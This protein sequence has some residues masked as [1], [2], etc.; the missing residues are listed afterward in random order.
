MS[1]IHISKIFKNVQYKSKIY[2][3][4]IIL[5]NDLGLLLD[6]LECPG[7]SKDNIKWFWEPWTRPEIPKS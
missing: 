2:Y 3:K 4:N 1:G 5:Q 7:A 6:Y